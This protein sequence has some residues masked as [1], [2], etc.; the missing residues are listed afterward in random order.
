MVLP[1]VL[2]GWRGCIL[3]LVIPGH[4]D[5]SDPQ[6][7]SRHHKARTRPTWKG[8][9]LAQKNMARWGVSSDWHSVQAWQSQEIGVAPVIM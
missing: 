6:T 3:V 4:A 9:T 8:V 1:R 5:E 7:T 2:Q